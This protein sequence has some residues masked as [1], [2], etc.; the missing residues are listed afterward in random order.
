MAS[1]TINIIRVDACHVI[2]QMDRKLLINMYIFPRTK[3]RINQTQLYT[4][5][6]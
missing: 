1:D 2:C 4:Q 5:A 3:L 6:F